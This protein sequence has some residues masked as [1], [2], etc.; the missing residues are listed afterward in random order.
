M[1]KLGKSLVSPDTI[2]HYHCVSR[3]VYHAFTALNGQ[4]FK[5]HQQRTEWLALQ[6]TLMGVMVI[7]FVPV[8]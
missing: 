2:P 4:D 6:L 5:Q 8:N 3:C 1:P 7:V